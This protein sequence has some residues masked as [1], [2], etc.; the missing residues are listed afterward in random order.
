MKNK[1]RNS[2]LLVTFA[3][4]GIYFFN[5]SG[6]KLE[7]TTLESDVI[8]KTKKKTQEKRRLFSEERERH[9][10]NMQKNPVTGIIPIEE[11]EK[12][13]LK[14]LEAKEAKANGTSRTTSSM[15]TSRGP[16]NFGGRTRAMA[17]DISDGSSNTILAGG[18][19]SGLFRTTNGGASW[20]KVSANDEIHNVTALAQDP[21]NTNIWYYG[22]GEWSGNSASLGSAYRGRGVWKSTDS[23]ITWTQI[24]GTDSAQENFDSIYDYIMALEVSPINGELFIAATGKIIRFNGTT[25]TT[26]LEESG[27][28]TGW[29]DVVIND[30]GAVYATI[31]GTSS[32]NGVYTSPTGNGSWTRIAQNGTPATWASS[33][34][35]V[36]ASSESNN[37]IIYVMFMNDGTGIFDADLWKYDASGAGV[38]TDYSS[39]LP[40]EDGGDLAGNDPFT[41]QGGYDLVV[42]VKPNDEDFVVIGGSNAYRIEDIVNDAEFERIGGYN[43]NAN[44]ALYPNHHPDI[45]ALEFDP[46]NDNVLFSGTDGGV[47]KTTNITNPTIIWTTLNNNYQTYQYYHVAMDD[48]NGS[49]IVIGG[50]QDNGTT[51]GGTNIGQVDNTTMQEWY[52]G[53]GVAVGITRRN[54]GANAQFYY[55]AQNGIARTNYPDFRSIAPTGSSS[56]FV[57]YF[58][59]DP[60]STNAMYF[61]GETSLYATDDAENVTTAINSGN[62]RYMG[63]LPISQNLRSFATSPGAYS[64]ASSYLLIGGQNGGVFRLDDPQNA[65][66]ASTAVDVTP[67]GASTTSGS[68]VSGLATHPTNPDIA[69]AVYANYGINSIY[70]TDNLT[71][72]ATWTLVERNLS[73]HSI[74]SAAIAEVGGET[75]YFVGTAR[76]LYSSDDPTTNDWDIEGQNEMGFALIS[77]LVYRPADNK[78]LI[79]THGNGMF[80]T[81][82]E[83]TLSVNSFAQVGNKIS[84]YPNPAQSEINFKSTNL[85]LTENANYSIIDISGKLV[86]SGEITNKKVNVSKLN[87]GLYFVTVS[88]KGLKQTLKFIK[89]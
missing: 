40:D 12:E 45:H 38:W 16:T 48:T 83:N 82:V 3:L 84:V 24:P 70:I 89:K 8:V 21:T 46:N 7:V 78:M 61:A 73:A 49:D 79:G 11:K 29:T 18:V 30:A 63:A 23:G 74:R 77:G 13:F 56:Q 31:E 36:L 33:G 88:T 57:T 64:A 19:S 6:E 1:L 62:W 28:G 51:I 43:S 65:A 55:G 34:R 35:T 39:K 47:H 81:T 42:S 15:Y 5:D 41:A 54:G 67:T 68:V 4:A 60:A 22:A 53:D 9:E 72:T 59:L 50:A 14:S 26:E 20:T 25:L 85:N 10:F 17:V 76:G 44:Y 69:I 75:I 66:S 87:S 71:T 52:G 2:L 37:D 32:Q 58:Y 27:G 86:S 80:E